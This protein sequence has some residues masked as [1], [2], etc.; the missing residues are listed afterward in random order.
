MFSGPTQVQTY[1][2]NGITPN[3]LARSIATNG[4]PDAWTGAA[5]RPRPGCTSP[6]SSGSA[7]RAG[8]ARSCWTARPG[9]TLVHGHDPPLGA[10]AGRDRDNPTV[11]IDELTTTVV[12]ENHHVEIWQPYVPAFNDAV[13]NGT[14]EG[15]RRT[16][17][18][19]HGKRTPIT[20][21]PTSTST[22]P[23]RGSGWRTASRR[24]EPAPTAPMMQP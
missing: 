2:I 10:A 14:C 8:P 17:K 23:P 5:R 20:A 24:T 4:P 12:H 22:A 16:W 6:I 21:S 18:Q 13:L 1:E 7:H 19:L 3:E 11:V 9:V 15:L